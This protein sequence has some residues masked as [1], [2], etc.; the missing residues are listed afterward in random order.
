[1]LISEISSVLQKVCS[2]GA[3]PVIVDHGALALS[4]GALRAE[5][6]ELYDAVAKDNA[7]DA[8]IIA[9]RRLYGSSG[10][11][12]P[13][14]RV[15]ELSKASAQNL[16][17]I[18]GRDRGLSFGAED[19]A[20]LA[21]Y[22]RGYPPA[23]RFAIDEVTVRGLPQVV[24]NQRALVNFSAEIF[25]RQ[26]RE[27]ETLTKTRQAILQLLSN[28]SPLPTG[29]IANYCGLHA[30]ALAEELAYLLDLAFVIPE[31]PHYRIS[32]PLRDA[33]YRAYD[34]VGTDHSKVAAL[35]E[36]YLKAEPDEDS[37]ISL[38][39]SIFRASLLSGSATNS[40]F[41]ISFASDLISIATQS[42]HDQDY[43]LAIK[44]G[45]VAL[46]ARPDNIDVRRYVA[47]A[48]IRKEK[49]LD[50][51][52]H[53]AELIRLGELKEAY[54]TK[55]FAARR[56][57]DYSEAIEN[58]RKSMANGRGGVAIHRELA[59]CY[60]EL[61]QLESAEDHIGKAEAHSPHNRYVV[62][63]RCTIALRLGDLQTAERTLEV[64]ERVDNSGFA[65]HR[66]STFEQAKGNSGAA[67][68]L[69]KIAVGKITR[70]PFEV[71]ANLVNC[72]IEDGDSAGALISLTELQ[73][74]FGSTHH[75]AQVGLR[76]KYEIRFG[77]IESAQG[78][79]TRIRDKSTSVHHGLRLSILNKI[80]QTGKL[81]D[82]EER[83]RQSLLARLS[84][85]ESQR[86]T[87]LLG[88]IISRSD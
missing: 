84:D 57:R 22:S 64:L 27:D 76:C 11:N 52:P 10:E 26:L 50:A 40:R 7:V 62:D 14:V 49:Y 41:S 88:S 86:M 5:Y 61:G 83:E 3:L 48:L 19:L 32:E 87:R 46:E 56:Q 79:W 44:Y 54:Y 73:Q 38:G 65:E 33:A 13:S 60:F 23:V 82:A 69:A 15:A 36:E 43:D 51:E 58:Y 47:Q 18:M 17:R 2:T 85:A 9:N 71:Y 39:Q 28:Y 35:L 66:R 31:G 59:S 78:L 37:R 34:G 80:A 72:Q 8:V 6:Q 68:L 20:S 24:S 29:V 4:N 70:P 77:S 81:T 12:L 74:K 16:I 25:L 42:Y 30:D 53:I 21:T 55:G 67:L 75:D 63:L 45:A 1:M